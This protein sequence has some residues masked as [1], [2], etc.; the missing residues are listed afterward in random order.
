MIPPKGATTEATLDWI[1]SQKKN[2]HAEKKRSLADFHVSI[3]G[4]GTYLGPYDEATDQLYEE[5]I[6]LA[7]SSGV[8][9]IDTAI[10]YRCQRSERSIGRVL[11]KM[12]DQ[13]KISR[14]EIVVCTK[15]GFIP[16]EL[17][18]PESLPGYIEKNWINTG[19]VTKEDIV[20][21]CH[22][23]HPRFL[24]GMIDQS[25]ANLGLDTIDI[26]Y[27]H[28][29]ETQLSGVESDIFYSRLYEAFCLLE[30]NVSKGKIQ[31]YGL[32][33]WTAFRTEGNEFISLKTV[34][35]LAVKAGGKS[36]HLKVI[37]LPYNLAMLEAVGIHNQEY[38][39]ET[40]PI[41]SAAS[42]YGIDVVISAPLLQ[43][44]LG[45]LPQPLMQKLPGL[46]LA[47]GR[48]LQFVASTP[49]VAAALVGMRHK[50]HWQQNKAVLAEANWDLKVLE[51]VC[52]H[53][54]KG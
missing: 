40:Y 22:C 5:T 2:I 31:F 29:P 11:K 17:L 51:E 8:N 37:Q 15:G 12:Q 46:L 38:K 21:S 19:I 53:L 24:Q 4:I 41:L 36:H 25:L 52:R 10:N 3:L 45:H 18:P 34:L 28:N 9:L 32:A 27:L 30:E 44:Q 14:D 39:G 33:T 49:G 16:F 6:E 35:D 54:I 7:L 43:G 26:Y 23:L 1:S 13:K 20:S 42:F 47:P 48:A 50:A